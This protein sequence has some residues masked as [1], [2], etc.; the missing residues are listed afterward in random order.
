MESYNMWSFVNCF[1]HSMFSRFIHIVV[2]ISKF[3]SF[4]GP[5]YS[6]DEYITFYLPMNQCII[7]SHFDFLSFLKNTAINIC[8]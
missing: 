7:L 3:H 4:S 1:S 2:C 8:G 5:E 6:I